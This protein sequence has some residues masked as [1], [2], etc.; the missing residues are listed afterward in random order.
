MVPSPTITL[1]QY[2]DEEDEKEINADSVLNSTAKFT[3][4]VPK[5]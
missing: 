4:S 3:A 5:S 2:W 1:S